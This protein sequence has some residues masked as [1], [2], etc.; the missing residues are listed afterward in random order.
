MRRFR[1]RLIILVPAVTALFALQ[2]AEP[3]PGLYFHEHTGG[4]HPHVHGDL[5]ASVHGWEDAHP[6][7]HPFPHDDGHLHIHAYGSDHRLLVLVESQGTPFGDCGGLAASI[8]DPR[9]TGPNWALPLEPSTAH[10]HTQSAFDHSLAGAAVR[11]PAVLLGGHRATAILTS[12]AQ[13]PL[14]QPI[15]RG[16]PVSRFL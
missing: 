12:V 11:L 7:T 3:R 10:W 16:P 9:T 1:R 6:H 4:D 5:L 8:R 15:A 2:I 13:R 14:P